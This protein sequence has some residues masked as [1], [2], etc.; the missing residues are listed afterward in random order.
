MDRVTVFA[1]QLPLETDILRTGQF[2][3]VGT[4]KLGE[5]VLGTAP[6][7]SGFPIT[8]TAP[9][10]LILNL[11]AGTVFQQ[12]P[13]EATP[14]S[15]LP[16]DTAHQIMKEGISL[17]PIP[18]TFTP[19]ATTGYSQ[20]F[21]V[22]VQYQE[23]DS[24][25]VLRPYFNAA[26]PDVQFSGPGGSGTKDSTTRKGGVYALIKPGAAV[27][28]AAPTAPAPDSGFVG[29]YVVTIAAGATQLTAANNLSLCQRAVHL[30]D[31]A[32]GPKCRSKPGLGS[33]RG[34]L[35]SR[36]LSPSR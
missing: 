12:E 8:A 35:A 13:L 32:A 6:T 29:L 18:L 26:D 27:N 24:D 36:T 16:A 4:A 23:S 34:T 20:S 14:W 5:A 33:M 1:G 31:A 17:D 19:P 11:G 22:Q 30:H 3:M 15:S 9:A 25:L 21:L 28:S 7:V 2:A 10:S